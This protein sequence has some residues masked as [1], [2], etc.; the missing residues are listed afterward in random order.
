MHL[1]TFLSR[2]APGFDIVDVRAD[3][4]LHFHVQIGIF[5]DELGRE[6]VKQAEHIVGDQHLSITTCTRASQ[7]SVN[8]GPMR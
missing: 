2:E 4:A 6:A 5:L 8:R 7:P 3:G 1:P